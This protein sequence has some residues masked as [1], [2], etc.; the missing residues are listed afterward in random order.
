M[1]QWVYQE[2]KEM[3]WQKAFIPPG[4]YENFVWQDLETMLLLRPASI[5]KTWRLDE[6]LM[7]EVAIATK[8][9]QQYFSIIEL[10]LTS[11]HIG[12]GGALS[13][14]ADYV[15]LRN[16]THWMW[17]LVKEEL[18]R[19]VRDEKMCEE[20]AQNIRTAVQMYTGAQVQ[21]ERPYDPVPAPPT[22]IEIVP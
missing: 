3:Q 2:S 4:D 17:K 19:Y 16:A 21:R 7:R 14:R 1:E 12:W 9:N 13:D 8:L 10:I 20:L 6:P 22:N 11:S 5:S 18:M 15:Q